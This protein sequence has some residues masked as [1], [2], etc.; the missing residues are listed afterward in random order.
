MRY[1][2]MLGALAMLATALTVATAP[3]AG[4]VAAGT[5]YQAT[6]G[7]HNRIEAVSVTFGGATTV[8]RIVQRASRGR[9][10]GPVGVHGN[11]LLYS[12]FNCHTKVWSFWVRHLTGNADAHRVW[13][14]SGKAPVASFDWYARH[15]LVGWNTSTGFRLVEVGTAH[16]AQTAAW[17]VHTRGFLR[18]LGSGTVGTVYAD[19]VGES[20]TRVL[21]REHN[22]EFGTLMTVGGT[23]DGF[24]VSHGEDIA[25]VRSDAPAVRIDWGPASFAP[26][27]RVCPGGVGQAGATWVDAVTLLVT[28]SEDGFGNRHELAV[29]PLYGPPHLHWLTGDG[30]AGNDPVGRG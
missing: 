27:A 28:C 25:L 11:R 7:C 6:Y 15:V 14:P 18:G 30:A 24:A 22:Q 5:F 3:T 4:A 21:A 9:E 2:R 1:L 13:G 20:S 12:V 16:G 19:V 8:E 23:N 10:I 29:Y 26:K 17:N